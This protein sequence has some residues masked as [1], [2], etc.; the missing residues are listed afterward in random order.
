MPRASASSRQSPAETAIPPLSSPATKSAVG[1]CTRNPAIMVDL[2]GD[3]AQGPISR[4]I[5]TPTATPNASH[6]LSD[7][8]E[9]LGEPA[10]DLRI[11]RSHRSGIR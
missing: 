8:R 5:S 10:M 4:T 6:G 2:E 3:S 9:R 11:R 1:S 7:R